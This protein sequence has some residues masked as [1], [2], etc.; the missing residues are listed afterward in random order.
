VERASHEGHPLPANPRLH[1]GEE[2]RRGL[3]IVSAFEKSPNAHLFAVELVMMA[4]YDARDPSHRLRAA[5]GQKEDAFGKLPEGVSAGI[6]HPA[7]LFLKG[8]D[9]FGVLRIDFPRQV[10]EV[11]D[12]RSSCHSNDLNA[13]HDCSFLEVI[14]ETSRQYRYSQFSFLYQ[15]TVNLAPLAREIRGSKPNKVLAF[16]ISHIQFFWIISSTLP[17]L[18]MQGFPEALE[19]HF[20]KKAMP[21]SICLG[22]RSCRALISI[23]CAKMSPI[24]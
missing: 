13:G 16:V 3:R 23:A 24:S 14:I 1:G 17:L 6:Q 11:L 7:N 5:S 12:L 2:G 15:A 18:M 22:R 21:N 8:G 10:N 9:P 4:I 19:N 20:A